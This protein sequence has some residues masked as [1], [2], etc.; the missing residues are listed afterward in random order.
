MSG[1]LVQ[2]TLR[3]NLHMVVVLEF[4]D[5][6]DHFASVCTNGGQQKQ[7]L[8]VLVVAERRWLDDDLLQQLDEFNPKVC[9][10]KGVD[11]DGNIIGVCGLRQR[12]GDNLTVYKSRNAT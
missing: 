4:V 11:G 6:T 3:R 2:T 7:V 12:S 1:L 8:Q 10:Q 9:S 5:I